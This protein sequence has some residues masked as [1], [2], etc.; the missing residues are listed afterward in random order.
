MRPFRIRFCLMTLMTHDTHDR[1]PPREKKDEKFY[2]KY[3]RTAMPPPYLCT[4]K[5]WTAAQLS[6]DNIRAS[7]HTPQR[8]VTI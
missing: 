4:R 1:T 7:P 2:A 6:P 8:S 3:S 5:T